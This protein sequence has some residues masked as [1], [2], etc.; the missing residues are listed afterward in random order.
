MERSVNDPT[1]TYAFAYDTM[2]WLI[3]TTTNYSFLSARSFTTA[4]TYDAASN[5]TS[6]TDPESG[7]TTYDNPDTIAWVLEAAHILVTGSGRC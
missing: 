4:Y 6:F 7:S 2:G 1:G 3:G 5:R